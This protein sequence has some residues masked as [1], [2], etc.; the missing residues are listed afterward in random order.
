MTKNGEKV[1]K[2]I[3]KNTLKGVKLPDFGLEYSTNN[4][5]INGIK[6]RDYV[7]S[8]ISELFKCDTDSALEVANFLF[9]NN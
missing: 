7:A 2:K 9:W 1:I 4:L 8:R 3:T 6:Y 5:Y